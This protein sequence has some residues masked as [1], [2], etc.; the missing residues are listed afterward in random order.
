MCKL[1]LKRSD[2]SSPSSHQLSIAPQ[3]RVGSCESLSYPCWK[4]DWLDLS[5]AT[6]IVNLTSMVMFRRFY[7]S[8]VPQPLALTVFA[9]L[10]LQY[11]LSLGDREY[12]IGIPFM[13]ANILI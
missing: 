13:L 5:Q 7:F 3:L 2:S 11:S 8:V 6:T 12:V 9:P 10:L 4:G 1:P